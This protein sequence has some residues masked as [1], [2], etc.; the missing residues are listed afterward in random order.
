[1][2]LFRDLVCMQTLQYSMNSNIHLSV[3]NTAV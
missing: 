2:T 1:V 3:A